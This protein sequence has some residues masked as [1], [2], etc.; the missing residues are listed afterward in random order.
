M[1][2]YK[3]TI[4]ELALANGKKAKRIKQLEKENEKIKSEYNDMQYDLMKARTQAEKLKKD[5]FDL[6]KEFTEWK[7]QKENAEQKQS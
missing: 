7:S 2:E 1:K 5:L 6:S 3:A 4:L